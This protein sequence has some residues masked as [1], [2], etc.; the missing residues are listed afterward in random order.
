MKKLLF[1]ISLVLFASVMTFAQYNQ[2]IISY[3]KV[4][5]RERT[6]VP[7]RNNT[8]SHTR[9]HKRIHRMIDV[10]QKQNLPMQ[11]PKAPLHD[12][13][14]D[15]LTN[16]DNRGGNGL[17]TAYRTEELSDTLVYTRSEV[18]ARGSDTIDVPIVDSTGAIVYVRVPNPFDRA[19]IKKYE[20]MED[21]IFDY[22][23][24]DFRPRIIA[25][26]PIFDLTTSGISIGEARMFWIK[27]EDLRPVLA[28]YETFN[29]FNDGSRLSYD[30][31]FE[32][33][34]FASHI[35]KES[36]VW[37]LELKYLPENEGNPFSAL[38]AS[39]KIKNDLFVFEHDIWEY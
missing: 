38:L 26:A 32:M 2:E 39:E 20:V 27:M 31:W 33:R 37:D 11:W 13:L 3:R 34:M 8:E 1:L 6:P 22:N 18:L 35:T 10:R 16:A 23:Y 14:F 19:S 28:R 36:N 15:A 24:S 7:H 30:D 4:A 5:P 17:V 12:I 29:P 9:Y 25:I 21:W